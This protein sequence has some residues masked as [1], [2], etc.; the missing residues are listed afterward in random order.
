MS[1][2]NRGA[3]GEEHFNAKL[4]D[5][6]VIKAIQLREDGFCYKCISLILGLEHINHDTL[7]RAIRGDTWKHII[8]RRTDRIHK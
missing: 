4:T 1:K 6:I 3:P 2:G 7:V 8:G 5:A